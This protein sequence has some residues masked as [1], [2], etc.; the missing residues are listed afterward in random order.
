MGRWHKTKVVLT[1]KFVFGK[2]NGKTI[3]WL[4]D[5]DIQYIDWALGEGV[6][7]WDFGRRPLQAQEAK[8]YYDNQK[9][10]TPQ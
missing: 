2:H 1:S 5:N 6:I 7:K 10:K 8:D 4:I 3:E 9:N